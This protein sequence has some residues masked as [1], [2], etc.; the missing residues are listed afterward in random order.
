MSGFAQGGAQT[1]TLIQSQV[2][3]APTAPVTFS[4]IPQT[5]NHL[6]LIGL[7]RSAYA[8]AADQF[9]ITLNGAGHTYGV[10]GVGN[11]GSTIVSD[12]TLNT[13]Q[14]QSTATD[15]ASAFMNA[16][17]ATPLR[18]EI[19]FYTNP[20]WQKSG[21]FISGWVSG[22]DL[23]AHYLSHIFTVRDVFAAITSIQIAT[24]QAANFVA[25][26]AFSLYGIN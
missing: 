21:E 9:S 18:L 6:R 17:V 3:S 15:L 7:C 11:T 10:L 1:F 12:G 14:I 22:F 16:S 13:N 23:T 25:G 26:S 8:V 20:N 2:L 19:P 24:L 5:F 4:A